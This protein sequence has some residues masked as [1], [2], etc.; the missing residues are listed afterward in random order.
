MCAPYPTRCECREKHI[1]LI[2]AHL[3]LS[4]PTSNVY[5][6]SLCH[7]SRR[8]TPVH[9]SHMKRTMLRFHKLKCIDPPYG[10][11][12]V[13]FFLSFLNIFI[14]KPIQQTCQGFQVLIV[15]VPCNSTLIY[16][17]FMMQFLLTQSP[18]ALNLLCK[19]ITPV[20]AF[21][22]FRKLYVCVCIYV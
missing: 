5:C 11:A 18:H 16:E 3:P 4:V 21:S 14:V 13:S 19:F 9:R 8:N 7:R 12:Y 1:H 6:E 20:D 15:S 10:S 2:K 17:T 22:Q